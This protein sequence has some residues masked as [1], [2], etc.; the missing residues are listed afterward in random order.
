LNRLES[1]LLL[2]AGSLAKDHVSEAIANKQRQGSSSTA[3]TTFTGILHHTPTKG[4]ME[5]I[6]KRESY[7]SSRQSNSRPR[8]AK[9]PE[10]GDLHRSLFLIL[11]IFEHQDTAFVFSSNRKSLFQI[12]ST[13][14]DHSDNVMV[15]M[16][17]TRVVGKWL[18]LGDGGSP[19][20]VKER[21][22]FLW[23]LSSFDLRCL[24]NDVAAQPLSKNRDPRPGP[25]LVTSSLL[26]RLGNPQ[27]IEVVVRCGGRQLIV[28]VA[29]SSTRQLAVACY[30]GAM[31]S[32]LL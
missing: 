3:K 28:A 9:S 27:L 23:K 4:I 24:A 8:N 14:L 2:L 1:S 16:M 5:E 17:S 12:L 19:V 6:I 30:N 20:I 11:S 25:S 31:V 13:L 18:L 29:W 26:L 22:S 32:L 10:N 21:N 7:D 15:L